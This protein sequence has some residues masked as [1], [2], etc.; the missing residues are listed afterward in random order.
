LEALIQKLGVS[1][2]DVNALVTV[3]IARASDKIK[4]LAKGKLTSK[5]NIKVHAVSASAKSA[6]EACGGSVELV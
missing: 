6:I 1:S 3:G 2:I 5:V 4:I